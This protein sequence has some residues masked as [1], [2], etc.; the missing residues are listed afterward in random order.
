VQIRPEFRPCR[1]IK[2]TPE[3]TK[4]KTR[5]KECKAKT[6]KRTGRQRKKKTKHI[7]CPLKNNKNYPQCVSEIV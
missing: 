6:R 2:K 4:R 3:G 7:L 1:V 5:E